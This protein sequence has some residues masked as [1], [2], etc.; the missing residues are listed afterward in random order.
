[1]AV[2]VVS[3][4]DMRRDQGRTQ[5]YRSALQKCPTPPIPTEINIKTQIGDLALPLEANPVRSPGPDQRYY[6]G[7]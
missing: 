7:S 6:D 1:M 4:R 3:T 5:I 2:L